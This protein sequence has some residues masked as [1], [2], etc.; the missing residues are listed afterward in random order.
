MST[1]SSNF[2]IPAFTHT[3]PIRSA[4]RFTKLN[5]PVISSLWDMLR[6][7]LQEHACHLSFLRFEEIQIVTHRMEALVRLDE[8]HTDYWG[9]DLSSLPKC[10]GTA[11]TNTRVGGEEQDSRRSSTQ[12]LGDTQEPST[13]GE[14]VEGGHS[15][16]SRIIFLIHFNMMCLDEQCANFRWSERQKRRSEI[17]KQAREVVQETVLGERDLILKQN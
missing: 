5:G 16:H 3:P 15:W 9:S 6:Q 4:Y 14:N 12:T 2:P 8:R 11:F 7:L 10:T 1:Y 17:K 13:S